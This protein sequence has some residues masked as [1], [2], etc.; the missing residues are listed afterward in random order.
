MNPLEAP[1]RISFDLDTIAGVLR[2]KWWIVPL[3]MLVG[4]VLMFWQESDLQTTPRYVTTYQSYEALDELAPLAVVDLNPSLFQP[5]PSE[6]SQLTILR[7][8]EYI[9]RALL[10]VTGDVALRIDKSETR[11]ELSTE[12]DPAEVKRFSFSPISNRTYTFTCTEKDELN[13]PKAIKNYLNL[14]ITLRAES[15]KTGLSRS[16]DLIS[17]VLVGPQKVSDSQRDQLILQKIAIEES[18]QLASGDLKF[19]SESKFY[20]GE[21]ISTVDRST[22]IFG[23]LVGFLV[24]CLILLQVSLSDNSIRSRKKLI[25]VVG[26]KSYLGSVDLENFPN[27]LHHVATSVHGAIGLKAVKTLRII[28]IGKNSDF[29]S[30]ASGLAEA[31]GFQTVLMD[32][33]SSITAPDLTP[34]ANSPIVLFVSQNQGAIPELELAWSVA[35]KSGNEVL[36]AV[37]IA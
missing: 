27:S 33:I 26:Y 22:Y 11:F 2:K 10:G 8:D 18:I 20:G 36:G 23:I 1:R 13:C 25:S 31:L 34:N 16:L 4:F 28:P 12:G 15:V 14:L 7:S 35:G 29:E 9:K 24:G 6:T 32:P 21:Q 37:L 5:V 30:I 19:I 3:T 17:Q